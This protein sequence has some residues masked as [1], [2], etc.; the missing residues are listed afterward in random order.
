MVP[1]FYRT[2]C[3][4]EWADK[5]DQY[6]FKLIN[7]SLTSP[8]LD[9]FLPILRYS[10]TWIPLYLFLITFSLLNFGKGAIAWLMAAIVEITLSDQ[11]SS[12]LIKPLVQRPRPCA[13]PLLS[14]NINLLLSH[15]PGGFS[16]PSS[17]AANHFGMAMFFSLTLSP[18]L[19]KTYPLFFLWATSIAYAQ[20]YVGAHY[21][22]DV[23]AGAILGAG[24]GWL[25]ASFYNK[26]FSLV[27]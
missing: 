19:H 2:L 10:N 12:H 7:H 5:I 9:V 3:F 6:I 17:H 15:C 21:P 14:K 20:V 25:V 26:Y 11:T 1:N 24:I 13:D 22:I 4:W 23:C 18:Y 16:F 27:N 8:F